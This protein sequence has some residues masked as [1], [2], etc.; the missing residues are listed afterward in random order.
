[1]KLGLHGFHLLGEALQQRVDPL[2]RLGQRI[3]NA[4]ACPTAAKRLFQ[5]EEYTAH[6]SSLEPLHDLLEVQ[7]LERIGQNIAHTTELVDHCR[8]PWIQG[9]LHCA[10]DIDQFLPSFD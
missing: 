6:K 4:L 9:S 2:E 5:R 3:Q 1:M 7:P 10:D 8:E